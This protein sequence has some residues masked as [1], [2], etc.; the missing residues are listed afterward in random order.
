MSSYPLKNLNILLLR[1]K[2][3]MDELRLLLE[4]EGAFVKAQ[5]VL[6]IAPC[7]SLSEVEQKLLQY[8]PNYLLV[9][10]SNT[11][12]WYG[13]SLQVLFQNEL[14]NTRVIPIGHATE[15]MLEQCGIPVW[16]KPSIPSSEGLLAMQELSNIQNLSIT[17]LS[18]KEGRELLIPNLKA[19]GAIVNKIET[20]ERVSVDLASTEIANFFKPCPQLV[21]ITSVSILNAFIAIAEKARQ[22]IANF[23]CVVLSSRI[24]EEAKDKGFRHVEIC[25]ELTPQGILAACQAAVSYKKG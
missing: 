14:I 3:Q 2:E 25:T 21:I 13:K 17:I 22:S 11:V 6:S 24:A 15:L 12:R 16:A 19:R 18:G 4:Q 7:L 23:F 1:P 10:S 8:M 5:P 20:Y 9:L